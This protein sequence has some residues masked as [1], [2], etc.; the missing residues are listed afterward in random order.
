MSERE[1]LGMAETAGGEYPSD[2][3]EHKM[4]ER[5]YECRSTLKVHG[6]A[7]LRNR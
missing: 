3:I 7:N 6:V 1:D 4:G 5:R 2:S